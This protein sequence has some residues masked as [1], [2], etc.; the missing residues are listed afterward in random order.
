[1]R[2]ELSCERRTDVGTQEDLLTFLKASKK[3]SS[4]F[5]L[6]IDNFS[7]INNAYGYAVGNEILT[8]V[9]T[10]LKRVLPTT[11]KLYTYH[12]DRFIC[13]E[14]RVLTEEE[15]QRVSEEI[16]SFF[17]QAEVIVGRVEL[18]I[19]L[20]IGVSIGIGLENLVH[21]ELAVKE[22]REHK[23][24][25]YNIYN[26]NSEFIQ[27]QEKNIY[28]ILK[29]KEA[30]ANEDIVAYFQ[31]IINNSTGKVEK[32]E[33]LA[34][35]RDAD[36]IISPYLFLDA[37]KVT[38]SLFYVTKSLIVQSFKK[39]SNTSYDFSINITGTDLHLDYLELF[40]LKNA[41]KYNIHPSRVIL[42]MLEDITSLDSG[43]TLKQLH[44]MR[45]KG[46]QIAMDDFGAENSNMSRLI[47][48]SPDYLK[49]DGV[50][51]KNI[52]EDR[53]CEIIVESIVALCKKCKVKIVAE[54]VHSA[55]VQARVK[56]LGIE[57]SQGYYFGAP[58]AEL[59][60]EGKLF[61]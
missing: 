20:S 61:S 11:M 51:I 14:E 47:E 54:Y 17:S 50:F 59:L 18:K 46:F 34:R 48:I 2:K 31:P 5:L 21:A 52:L 43:T 1:M 27:S 13:I 44:S 22:L 16:L 26:K 41:K 28:W 45:E 9:V 8:Q 10:F 60:E 19:S 4:C 37:A 15:I 32:Y 24:N 58:S 3:N 33:C 38:G 42:E 12:S 36:E 55:E 57:Y 40:L 39:F 30:V 53:K 25:H 29:I 6:N 23:R 56:E 35:L 7:N 49:I